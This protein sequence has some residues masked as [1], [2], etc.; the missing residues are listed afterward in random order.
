MNDGMR[1]VTALVEQAA[2]GIFHG[3]CGGGEDVGF[4]GGEMDDVFIDKA[5]GDMKAFGIDFVQAEK[6]CGEVP[7][8]IAYVDPFFAF[9]EMYIFQAV[10]F[11]DGEVFVFFFAQTRVDDY[12][13]IVATVNEI[14]IVAIPFHG[15]DNTVELP[16]RCGTSGEKKVPGN[17]DFEC[18]LHFS[19]DHILVICQIEQAVVVFK[20]RTRRCAEDSDFA[21]HGVSRVIRGVFQI[22]DTPVRAW[23]WENR[24]RNRGVRQSDFLLH[25]KGRTRARQR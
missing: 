25:R 4:D 5:F 12:G 19:G 15:A 2:K 18:G 21:L 22:I 10:R 1:P 14:G 16:G 17:V 20:N 9:V 23:Y 13:S 11:D 8:G 3:A 24:V 6:F 7:D